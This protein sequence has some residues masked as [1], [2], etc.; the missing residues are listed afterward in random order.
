MKNLSVRFGNNQVL[1]NI[2]LEVPEGSVTVI[3][4]P[5]GS[6]K[7]TLLRTLNLLQLPS[8]GEVEVDRVLAKAGKISKATI[9]KLRQKSTMVFQQFNLFKNLTVLENVMS[10][11]VYNKL[12]KFDDARQLALKTL[13]EFGLDKIAKQY[14]VTLSGG[15][16]QR[17]SIARALIGKPKVILFDEPTSALD[18]EMVASVLNTIATLASEDITMVIVTHEIEFARQVADQAVFVEGGSVV[19][20]G[21]AKTLLSPTRSDRIAA[22]VNS[23]ENRAPGKQS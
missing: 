15:Q 17:V 8:T 5:S 19:D 18:P 10:P 4:G 3:V 20:Q 22:F 7:T 1:K 6:G 2:N 12:A 9:K 11:L 23:L 21:P 13:T 16:Q 14:P